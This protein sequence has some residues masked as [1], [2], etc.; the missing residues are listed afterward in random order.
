MVTE[1]QEDPYYLCT[2]RNIDPEDI[3]KVNFTIFFALRVLDVAGELL[4]IPNIS[5]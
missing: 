1:K 5:K 3:L 2:E 4:I